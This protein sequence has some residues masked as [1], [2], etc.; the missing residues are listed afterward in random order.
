MLR[1]LLTSFHPPPWAGF[2]MQG[3]PTYSRNMLKSVGQRLRRLSAFTSATCSRL[4]ST[5][6]FGSAI[7]SFSAAA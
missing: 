2:M 4:G 1:I 3:N 5:T 7:P 6:V